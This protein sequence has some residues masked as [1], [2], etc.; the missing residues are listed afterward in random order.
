MIGVDTSECV[1][2]RLE[3][4]QVR[5]CDWVGRIQLHQGKTNRPLP[6]DDLRELVRLNVIPSKSPLLRL[7]NKLCS[8][9]VQLMASDS[10]VN[11]HTRSLPP[12]PSMPDAVY[13]PQAFLAL[14]PAQPRQARRPAQ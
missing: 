10:Y 3:K 5:P 2:R 12:T 7:F 1:A 8:S 14:M 6:Q 13:D 11:R 4:E 9:A